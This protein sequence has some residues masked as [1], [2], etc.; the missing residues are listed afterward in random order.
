[1]DKRSVLSPVEKIM[2]SILLI[3]I[4]LNFYF[5]SRHSFLNSVFFSLCF[6]LMPLICRVAVLKLAK[7]NTKKQ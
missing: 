3:V 2:F 7:K 1:M 5:I 4:F 6:T